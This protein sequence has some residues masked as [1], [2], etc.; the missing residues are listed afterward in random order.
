[1]IGIVIPASLPHYRTGAAP[2]DVGDVELVQL[3]HDGIRWN[4][5]GD[6]IRRDHGPERTTDP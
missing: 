5:N 4:R 3:L 6:G 1:M 2:D